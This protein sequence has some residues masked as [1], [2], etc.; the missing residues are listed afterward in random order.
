[1]ERWIKSIN[2]TGSPRAADNGSRKIKASPGRSG[3]AVLMFTKK[4]SE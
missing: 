2:A 4:W 3:V 1:M